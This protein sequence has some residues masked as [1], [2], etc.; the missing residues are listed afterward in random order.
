MEP[1]RKTIFSTGMQISRF[2]PNIEVDY[3]ANSTGQIR[4]SIQRHVDDSSDFERIRTALIEGEMSGMPRHIDIKEFKAR[5][6]DKY[7]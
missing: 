6:I 2:N 1:K 5:M 7:S 3:G 4:N